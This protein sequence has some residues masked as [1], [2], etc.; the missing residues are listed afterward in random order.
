MQNECFWEY[1]GICLC[2]RPCLCVSICVQNISFCQSA[3]GG[4]D[5]FPNDKM[6]GNHCGK[7]RNCSLGAISPFLT[8]FSK[9]LYCRHL[10]P[11]ACLGKGYITFSN[12][13]SFICYQRCAYCNIVFCSWQNEIFKS[14]DL[15]MHLSLFNPFSHIVTFRC[16]TDI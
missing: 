11:R 15:L 12:S 5:P 2:V 4:I 6:V 10:K 1:T 14:C 7:R 16:T 13:S 9:D 3:G 8:V